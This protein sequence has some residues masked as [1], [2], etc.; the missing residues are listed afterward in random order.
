MPHEVGITKIADHEVI[1]FCLTET[2]EFEIGAPDPKAFPLEPPYKVVT[3]E[4]T[5]PADQRDLSRHCFRRHVLNSRVH[6]ISAPVDVWTAGRLN[7]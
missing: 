5:G 6:S 2:W 3:D 7:L 1:S 4:A